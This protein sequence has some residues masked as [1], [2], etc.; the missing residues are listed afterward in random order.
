MAKFGDRLKFLRER[1]GVSQQEVADLLEVNKQTI[2]GYERNVR[3][4]SGENAM[5]VYETL[6]DY[7]NVDLMYLLGKTDI[8]VRLNGSGSDPEDA[9]IALEVT[10]EELELIKA[11]RRLDAYGQKLT[12]MAAHLEE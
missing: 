2:S 5:E 9:D 7:F 3:R 11:Y 10:S 8:V 1:K 6:A 4:P 12:R